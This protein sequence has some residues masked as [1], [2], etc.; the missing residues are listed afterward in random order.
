[1][2]KN[3][4]LHLIVVLISAISTAGVCVF[5]QEIKPREMT[6]EEMRKQLQNFTHLK[7]EIYYN[8]NVIGSFNSKAGYGSSA[9]FMNPSE[10]DK[11]V[12]IDNN[13][14][15]LVVKFS[16]GNDPER[17]LLITEMNPKKLI[18]KS[19][20]EKASY[21]LNF[22]EPLIPGKYE[23]A[24]LRGTLI[25]YLRCGFVIEKRFPQQPDT[26]KSA[27]ADM[28][29]FTIKGVLLNK[30]GTPIKGEKVYIFHF[31]DGALAR[32]A[33]G[34]GYANPS[35]TS[36]A[37]G[38]FTIKFGTKFIEELPYKEYTVGIIRKRK[39]APPM[40]I[41]MVAFELDVFDKKTKI[42][43]VGKLILDNDELIQEP[44]KSGFVIEERFP[45]KSQTQSTKMTAE[46]LRLSKIMN[47]HE[48]KPLIAALKDPDSNIRAFAADALGK[49][50]DTLAV[51]P[52]IAALKDSNS[53][54]RQY[55]AQ[56]LGMI[57]DARAVK[58]LTVAL[59]DSDS[60]VRRDATLALGL[61]KDTRAVEFL[62][63]APKDSDSDV[64]RRA[65]TASFGQ[66]IKLR[67]EAIKK[68]TDQTLLA[69]IAKN[70][71]NWEIRLGAVENLT[72]QA[73]LVEIAKNDIKTEVRVAA[74][75]KLTDQTI[76]AE[77]AK[78]DVKWPVRKA[79]VDKL[80]NLD[81]LTDIASHDEES[82]VRNSAMSRLNI[83]QPPK[84]APVIKAK[85][86]EK[87]MTVTTTTITLSGMITDAANQPIINKTVCIILLKKEM[88]G[89]F[90]RNFCTQTDKKGKFNITKPKEE[91]EKY[92]EYDMACLAILTKDEYPLLYDSSGK[93]SGYLY[94][95]P[96]TYVPTTAKD[97][98]ITFLGPDILKKNAIDFGIMIFDGN[99]L[100]KKDD[101]ASLQRGKSQLYEV[102]T[103][104][105]ESQIKS[106]AMTEEEILKQGQNS[107][108]LKGEIYYNG[109]LTGLFNSE[110]GGYGAPTRFMNP[111]EIDKWV[112]I[113]N[114]NPTLIV[115]FSEGNEPERLLL[116]TTVDRNIKK[117]GSLIWKSNA[118]KASYSL[119]FKE[120]LMPG[121]YE[122]AITKGALVFFSGYGF[123]IRR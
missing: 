46:E 53:D 20:P 104:Q 17:L 105:G 34:G 33:V 58:P 6:E 71:T 116:T 18:W 108:H 22:D 31:N 32:W 44:P 5:G 29:S 110:V 55:A 52:L 57:G 25:S 40:I 63:V 84:E 89:M 7:G 82:F 66:E 91:F 75:E 24:V 21:S 120:P 111:S 38:R 65:V 48:V 15:T 37:K 60:N 74:V 28:G 68:L 86:E 99:K 54:V 121:Q 119:N 8:G 85:T 98:T 30:D 102:F 79:A 45:V 88:A 93:E 78:K 62:I 59:K 67:L 72:D 73:I 69:D 3:W 1:M 118:E 123:V 83:L 10:T 97:G 11:W 95:F 41:V 27:T 112:R 96:K 35:G 122:F 70:D 81:I 26:T 101:E 87:E 64:R 19:N 47:T 51:K 39:N 12:R 117:L 92:G 2:L 106:A 56:A 109:I 13:N 77:I 76:L 4:R 61:I 16:E 36:D 114:N 14:P 50:K 107:S 90:S 42:L 100:Y 49:M 9:S 80:N 103:Q 113:Y 115:K 23:F 43:D 94:L